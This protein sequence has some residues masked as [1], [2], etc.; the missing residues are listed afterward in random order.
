MPEL[1]TA[2]SAAENQAAGGNLTGARELLADAVRMGSTA[3]GPD[4]LDVLAAQ[5]RLAAVHRELGAPHEARRVLETVLE[6]GHRVHG[7][8]HPQLL[9][10]SYDLAVLAHELGNAYEAGKNFRL[11]TKW[12]P[13]VLGADHPHVLSARRYLGEDVPGDIDAPPPLPLPPV[14]PIAPGDAILRGPAPVRRNRFPVTAAVAGMALLALVATVV[15]VWVIPERDTGTAPPLRAAPVAP[16]PTSSVSAGTS[17]PPSPSLSASG[18]GIALPGAG[19]GVKTPPRSVPGATPTPLSGR[20]F[21]HAGHTNMCLGLGPEL[22]VNSGRTVMGQHPC[23]SS[24]PQMRLEPATGNTYKLLVTDSDGTGCAD[25]DYAG[26][27]EGLLLAPRTCNDKPDQR[28]TFEPVTDPVAGYRLRS[29]AGSRFCIGVLEGKTQKG[30]QI[31]Q[32][33]CRNDA[34]EVFTLERR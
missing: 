29:V 15:A 7:V 4:H 20:Y 3:L 33:H 13:D 27:T 22:F 21:I 25:V 14:G 16:A 30:V 1:E 10:V 12:G 23:G 28:F 34:S 31:M 19:G 17:A 11:L 18:S 9:P 32:D 26:T 6:M 5:A 24:I 8:A 2:V